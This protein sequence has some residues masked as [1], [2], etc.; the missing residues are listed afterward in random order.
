VYRY[1][2]TFSLT[3]AIDKGV[4]LTPDPDRFTPA[5]DPVYIVQEA[6]WYPGPVWMGGE[7]SSPTGIRSLD[8]PVRSESPYTLNY[9]GHPDE[10]VCTVYNI[11]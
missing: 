7:I 10:H 4:W 11:F 2:S 6:G 8:C 5:K 9:A 1:S 3:S